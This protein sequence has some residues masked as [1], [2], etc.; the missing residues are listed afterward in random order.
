MRF[1]P[2]LSAEITTPVHIDDAQTASRLPPHT[3][4]PPPT[5][6]SSHHYIISRPFPRPTPTAP[7]STHL[8]LSPNPPPTVCAHHCL[9]T[10]RQGCSTQLVSSPTGNAPAPTI[11][12]MGRQR[13][14]RVASSHSLVAFT[15]SFPLSLHLAKANSSRKTMSKRHF[16][17]RI[18][19]HLLLGG[20]RRRCA[21]LDETYSR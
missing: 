18:R 5:T 14:E 9:F 16:S 17:A 15:E 2:Q 3:T 11:R 12:Q 13:A 20:T 21:S 6:A 19:C 7:H 4:I 10:A 8:P 1:L